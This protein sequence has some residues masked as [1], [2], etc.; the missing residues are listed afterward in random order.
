[1]FGQIYK[2]Y[3]SMKTFD[4]N[5]CLFFQLILIFLEFYNVSFQFM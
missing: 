4:K 5:I 2:N 1:M 3:L